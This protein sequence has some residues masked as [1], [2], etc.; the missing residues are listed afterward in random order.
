MLESQIVNRGNHGTGRERRRCVLNV[1]HIGF[2]KMPYTPKESLTL[3]DKTPLLQVF[4]DFHYNSELLDNVN[5]LKLF[6]I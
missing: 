1:E 5:Q 6:N 2:A 3:F 4:Q